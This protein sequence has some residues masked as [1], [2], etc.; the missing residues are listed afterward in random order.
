MNIAFCINRLA[1]KGLG[2]TL[3]SLIRNC[4]N[5]RNLKFSF[6]C[7]DLNENDREA[8]SQLL[9]SA[10]LSDNHTFINF[11]PRKDFGSFPSLHGDWTAYGRLLLGDFINEDQVLYLDADLVVELDVLEVETFDFDGNLLAAVGGGKFKYTLGKKF[12][13]EKLSIS[14]EFDYFNSGV[15]LFNLKEWRTQN[16]KEQCLE[17]ARKYQKDLPSHD[18]SLLNIICS[19]RFSKLPASFNCEWIA[20][21]PKPGISKKMILHF[22]GS[23]KPWDPLAF[24]FH[25]GYNTWRSYLRPEWKTNFCHYA[26]ADYKRTWKIRNSYLRTINMRLKS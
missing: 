22:V 13:I 17:I 12:Y 26:F 24:L 21:K 20:F 5:K 25:K 1:L 19:G 10:G 15:L 7:S 23:P 11:N 4:S 9:M 16:M 2:V 3:Y 18:Q 8:I 14:P 6:L